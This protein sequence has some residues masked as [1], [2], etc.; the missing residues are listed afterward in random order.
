MPLRPTAVSRGRSLAGLL[1]ALGLAC[2]D[3]R[4]AYRD[5]VVDY[6]DRPLELVAGLE[7]TQVFIAN[8][9]DVTA[10]AVMM[11]NRG[12]RARDCDVVF[13]LRAKDSAADID[14]QTLPCWQVPDQDWVRFDFPPLVLSHGRRFVISL[15]SPN[16][17]PGEAP[18]ILTAS[19]P[20]IYPDGKLRLGDAV[21]PGALR[22][23]TFHR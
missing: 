2:R 1:L 19:V 4:P 7:V 17:R 11:S 23:M 15:H 13:R 8:H 20:G 21:V 22:F 6:S 3:E 16:G 9:R 14:E 12:R 5:V 18:E 10:V